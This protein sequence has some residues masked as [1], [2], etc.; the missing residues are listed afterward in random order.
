MCATCFSTVDVV[1]SQALSGAL[2]LNRPIQN[3]LAA[4]GLVRPFDQLGEYANTVSF[5]ASLDLDPV[6]ILGADVVAAAATWRQAPW[7][8]RRLS[9]S[10]FRP[11][12]VQRA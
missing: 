2:L 11:S 6:N 12:G 8:R 10:S 3:R 9:F 4:A 7:S 5:L 1:V